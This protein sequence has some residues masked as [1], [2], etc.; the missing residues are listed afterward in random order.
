MMMKKVA[1]PRMDEGWACMTVVP[2][3]Q[4]REQGYFR[5]AENGLLKADGTAKPVPPRAAGRSG[6]R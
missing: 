1:T 3:T 6:R 2:W 5:K 4:W